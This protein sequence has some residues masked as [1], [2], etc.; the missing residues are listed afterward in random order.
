MAFI[1]HRVPEG[2][3]GNIVYPLSELKELYP[4]IFEV[5]S[6]HHHYPPH[7]LDDSIPRLGCF[8]NDVLHFTAMHP[9]KIAEA[10]KKCGH[11]LK[12]RY[13]EIPAERLEPEKTIV[14]LNKPR[15]LGSPTKYSDFVD[16]NPAEIEKYAFVHEES[17]EKCEDLP[18]GDEFLLNYGS[19]YILYKSN[20]NIGG[21]VIIEV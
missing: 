17:L 19:P 11:S 7:V 12:L 6:K 14:F 2:M 4:E 8:W 3:T 1:Y 5:R 21:L 18:T 15:I 20:I 9:T 16:Y 10:M 13:Y